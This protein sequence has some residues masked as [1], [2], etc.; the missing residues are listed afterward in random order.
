MK[1]YSEAIEDTVTCEEAQEIF[2]VAQGKFQEMAAVAF[3]NWGNIHMSQARKRLRLT[4][5]DEVVPVR[6]KEAYEWI[7]QEYT[8]AGKR[9]NEALDVKPDF[10]E[11]F[12]AIALK[13][14]EH[15]KLCWNYVINSKIDLEKSCIEVFE[16]FN[17]AEDSIEKGSAL[18]DEIER[19][20][21]RHLEG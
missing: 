12:L 17:K 10:Y 20:Q 2:E 8:K 4:E 5:E 3:F 13:K 11:A 16:M 18:W 19:R 15:A 21:M 1:L 7:R 14:F 6:V 9:Y